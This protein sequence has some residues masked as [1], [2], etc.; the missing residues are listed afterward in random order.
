MLQDELTMLCERRIQALE[1]WAEAA[2]AIRRYDEATA[3]LVAAVRASH[4]T[5]GCGRC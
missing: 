3:E 4:S 2:L 1:R 5:Q